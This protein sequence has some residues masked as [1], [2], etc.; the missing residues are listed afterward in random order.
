MYGWDDAHRQFVRVTIE[1]RS[2]SPK[3]VVEYNIDWSQH[4]LS[5]VY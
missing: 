3:E 5:V 2:P 4:E 1:V